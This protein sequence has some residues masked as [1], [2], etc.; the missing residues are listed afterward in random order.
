MRKKHLTTLKLNRKVISKLDENQ[1]TGGLP[2]RSYLN[3]CQTNE[4]T[5][6]TSAIWACPTYRCF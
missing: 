6:C 2:V 3:P 1:I 5:Y 4:P